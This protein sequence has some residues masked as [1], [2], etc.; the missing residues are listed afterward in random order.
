MGHGGVGP[1]CDSSPVPDWCLCAGA[2]RGEPGQSPGQAV[3]SVKAVWPCSPGASTQAAS[4]SAR[5][6]LRIAYG[7]GVLSF[8]DLASSAPVVQRIK[9]QLLKLQTEGVIY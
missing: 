8:G 2:T 5:T 3:R 9:S 4:P 6:S 1:S 7:T